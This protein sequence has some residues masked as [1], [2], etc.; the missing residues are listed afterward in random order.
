MRGSDRIWHWI[1]RHDFVTRDIIVLTALCWILYGTGLTAHG[2]TN[3]HEAERALAAREMQARDDWMV[4]TVNSQPYLSKPPMIYWCQLAIASLRH[5]RTSEFDLRLT[6]AIA[7]WLG[8]LITYVLARRMFGPP[9]ARWSAMFLATGILYVH[10]ARIGEIDILLVP[11]TVAAIGGVYLAWRSRAENKQ[12]NGAAVAIATV[13]ACG[14]MLTKGP[15]GL[16]VIVVAGYGG[17]AAAI[18]WRSR[19]SRSNWLCSIAVAI[20]AVG[21]AAW[22]N[23]TWN[24][25]AAIGLA[26]LAIMLPPVVATL[27]R[28]MNPRRALALVR[29]WAATD[30]WLVI[31]LPAIAFYAWGRVV[32]MRVGSAALTAAARHETADNLR[33]FVP[34]SA[35]DTALATIYGAGLGSIAGI[36]GLIWLARDRRATPA[37]W[38]LIGW[39][40]GGVVAFS[41]LTKAVPRYLTSVWPGLTLLGGWWIISFLRETEARRQLVTAAVISIILLTAGQTWWYAYG[42]YRLYGEPSPRAF[43]HEL[44]ALPGVDPSRLATF[45]FTTPLLDYYAN[46]PLRSVD[47][48][49]NATLKDLR[50]ELAADQRPL[51]LLVRKRQP[52]WRG[53]DPRPPIER[54]G[55]VGL[56]VDPIPLQTRFTID[57]WNIPVVALR[58]RLAR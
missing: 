16:L 32:E 7:G 35:L 21:M 9:E 14:A 19:G 39:V 44:L 15:P 8:V 48:G 26:L 22:S 43:I 50:A 53:V 47:A 34:H 46:Q 33:L 6:V 52:P 42:G 56:R 11:F 57:K 36:L 30:P 2:L 58:V 20:A 45:E 49:E 5:S 29:E 25:D 17:I 10:S 1:T 4:P 24:A 54:L 13:A 41:V 3:W 38:I 12:R 23:R 55:N 40:A 37:L 51:I 31:G 28:L 18:A 27:L